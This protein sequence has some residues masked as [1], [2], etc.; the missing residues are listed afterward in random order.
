MSINWVP[1]HWR[2]VKREWSKITTRRAWPGIEPGTSRKHDQITRSENHTTRPSG[3]D[4]HNR[5]HYHTA[6]FL[7]LPKAVILVTFLSFKEQLLNIK[8][9][10]TATTIRTC[11]LRV[12]VPIRLFFSLGK[13]K[14]EHVDSAWSGLCVDTLPYMFL[15]ALPSTQSCNDCRHCTSSWMERVFL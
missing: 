3:H 12:C 7:W 6:Y 11:R 15:L 1:S 10:T 5:E 14:K 2:R 13:R 9:F 8:C 4:M